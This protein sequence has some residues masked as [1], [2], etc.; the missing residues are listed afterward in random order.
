MTIAI[1]FPPGYKPVLKHGDHDQ[2]SHGNWATDNFQDYGYGGGG[3]LDAASEAYEE[4]YGI[5]TDG[6]KELVG[7]SDDEAK[8]LDFYTAEGYKEINTF[9]REGKDK[10]DLDSLDENELVEWDDIDQKIQRLDELI[11]FSPDVYG[12]KNLFRVF[13]EKVLSNLN[14]GD[15]LQ[16]K[17]FLSTTRVDITKSQNLETLETL[18]T[19]RDTPDV[20]AV[21]LPSPSGQGKAL[22]VD[23]LKNAIGD[24]PLVANVA[25]ANIEKEV[26]LPRG[27]SLKFKG[28][29]TVTEDAESGPLKVAV[30]ERVDK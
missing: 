29:K 24:S 8:A 20:P 26:L 16:D 22:G 14:E 4:R 28:Y 11:Q 19:I 5:K 7:I 2:S 13:S 25:T 18:Q 1:L 17:G 21:I 15:V 27:T 12:E 9:L 6:S 3:D 23:F 10:I 30:F